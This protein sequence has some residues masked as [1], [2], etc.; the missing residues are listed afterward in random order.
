MENRLIQYMQKPYKEKLTPEIEKKVK[1]IES[2]NAKGKT[3]TPSKYLKHVD[4]VL[5][6]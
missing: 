3:Y 2:G 1:L 5:D 4:K 6:D